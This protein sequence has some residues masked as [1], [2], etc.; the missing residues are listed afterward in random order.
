MPTYNRSDLLGRALHGLLEQSLAP[1]Q[2][3]IVVVDDGSTDA[4]PQVVAAVAAPAARLRYFR[5]ENKG[6]A[7]ARNYGVREAKGEIV[8]FTGDDCFPVPTL[9][10]EHLR[11]YDQEGDV[12]VIGHVAWHPELEVTPFM[13][14]L[15]EGIQF[16]FK[17]IE[18]PENVPFWS[19]YTSN[20]SVRKSRLDRVGG[21]DEDF[22]YAAYEDIEV[23]YRMQRKGLRLVYRP[24]AL[25][26]HH[27]ATTLERYL[28]RQR[29]AGRAAV[30]FW[31]KH[32][33]LGEDLSITHA[34]RLTTALKFFE[35]AA[36]YAHAIGVRDAL[37]PAR[38][39]EPSPVDVLHADPRLAEAGGGWIADIFAA[40]NPYQDEALK[41]RED[42]AKLHREI[43]R[44]TSRRLYR[45]SEAL[46]KRGWGLL[47]ALGVRRRPGV[48]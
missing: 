14:F 7:A 48:M 25:T 5:Q 19:F 38:A 15:E 3:E 13:S 36:E 23:G 9:L 24:A 45:W 11:T 39:D 34:A 40:S 20:C 2:Y 47:R 22:P 6:P 32:P 27:H 28:Q 44:I 43:T 16:G 10:E 12:G 8:L 33:E 17:H 26:Y 37:E 21:F 29:L 35:A 18:D 42:M 31:R 30:I 46:A 1:E 41:A 4:T